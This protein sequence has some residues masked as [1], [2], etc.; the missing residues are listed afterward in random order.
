MLLSQ[1]DQH[2]GLGT[3]Y[4]GVNITENILAVFASQRTDWRLGDQQEM[5]KRRVVSFVLTSAGNI[6]DFRM[7]EGNVKK[8]PL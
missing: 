6:D 5:H 2:D 7:G 4:L 1:L 8:T 3:T